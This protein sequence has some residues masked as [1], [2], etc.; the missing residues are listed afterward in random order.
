MYV[1]YIDALLERVMQFLS[2]YNYLRVLLIF[3]I[4]SF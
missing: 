3:H 1:K 2:N 4:V